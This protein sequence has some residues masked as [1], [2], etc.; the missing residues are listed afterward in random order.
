MLPEYRRAFIDSLAGACQAGLSLFAGQP[1]PEENVKPA[2]KLYNARYVPARNYNFFPINSSLYQCWQSGLLTWLADWQPDVLVVEANPRYPSTRLAV[3]WMHARGRPVVG[4]GLGAPPID[5][6]R[7]SAPAPFSQLLAGWQKWERMSFLRSLDGLIAYSQR[8]AQQYRELGLPMKDICVAPNAVSLRPTSDVPSI[9]SPVFDSPGIVLYVGRL[10]QR[11]RIDN[12]LRACA[13]LPHHLQPRL[14]IVGDG[15]A[16]A[17]LEQLA[18]ET[19]PRAEFF[20]AR[21]GS[22]LPPLFS[23][24]DLFVLPGTGGL[25]VQQAMT[26]ALPVIVA[27]GDGTQAD[28]VRPENG[29]LVPAQDLTALTAAL[30]AAL[31]DPAKLREMGAESYRIVYEEINVEAMVSAFVKALV[32]VMRRS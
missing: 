6:G 2:S 13:N 28:L 3:R 9:R 25:A 7:I 11:K 17:E 21:H 30:K 32:N 4:W 31:S 8:G 24:A 15:P 16:R 26:Y 12:L 10:Q 23:A 27:E 5:P 20:G 19:Y 22:E 29:F 1:L 18:N 14:W